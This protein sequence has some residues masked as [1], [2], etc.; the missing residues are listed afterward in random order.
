[1]EILNQEIG[2]VKKKQMKISELRNTVTFK[3]TL[4]RLQLKYI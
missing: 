3:K 4:D 1:M 2:D